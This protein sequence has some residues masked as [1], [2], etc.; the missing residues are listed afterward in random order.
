MTGHTDASDLP[1]LSSVQDAPYVRRKVRGIAMQAIKDMRREDV[2][3]VLAEALATKH[4]TP[5]ARATL[6]AA[7]KHLNAHK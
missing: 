5:L 6:E 2:P 1:P 7:L 3:G 4:G